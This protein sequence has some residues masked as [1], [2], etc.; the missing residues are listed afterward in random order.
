MA[1]WGGSGAGVPGPRAAILLLYDRRRDL[2]GRLSVKC[3]ISRPCDL[4]Y[5][6]GWRKQEI[7]GL[8]WEEIDM[9]GVVV[10]LSPARSKTLVGRI[11]PI[12]CG[13]QRQD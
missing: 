11:L 3:R 7:L 5:Y 10:R 4:A 9:A 1:P 12:S 13:K 8:T 2:D 6:S